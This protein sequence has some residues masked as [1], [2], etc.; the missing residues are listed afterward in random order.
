MNLDIRSDK[1]FS[2]DYPVNHVVA[3]ATIGGTTTNGHIDIVADAYGSDG[4]D[5]TIE[6]AV[7][8]GN[9]KA[10]ACT[11]T[12]TDILVTLGTGEAGA[13]DDTKNTATLITAELNKLDGITATKDGT[14][15]VALTTAET[16][17]DFTA[18]TYA[19]VQPVPYT[20]Y[21]HDNVLYFNIAPNDRIGTNWRSVSLTAY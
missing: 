9:N 7:A 3:K 13:V 16:K 20:G 2:E 12:G 5:F 17:A 6:V 14:G 8:S 18:G 1:W 15:A 21:I 19:T 11:L 4:N 10:M